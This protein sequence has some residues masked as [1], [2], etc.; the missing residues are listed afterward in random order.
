MRI[1]ANNAVSRMSESGVAIGDRV[2]RPQEQDSDTT[3]AGFVLQQHLGLLL[4]FFTSPLPSLRLAV[5]YCY[6]WGRYCAKEWYVTRTVIN[7]KTLFFLFFFVYSNKCVQ[8]VNSSLWRLCEFC[9]LCI[10]YS[11]VHLM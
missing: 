2:L 9:G 5:L 6:Y 11:F 3:V 7:S 4:K 1:E 10:L 8:Y